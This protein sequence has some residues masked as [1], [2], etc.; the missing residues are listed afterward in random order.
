[1]RIEEKIVNEFE[2]VIVQMVGYQDDADTTIETKAYNEGV[3]D[4]FSKINRVIDNY[5]MDNKD[6]Y[7]EVSLGWLGGTKDLSFETVDEAVKILS[8][9]HSKNMYAVDIP[10]LPVSVIL[11][12]ELVREKGLQIWQLFDNAKQLPEEEWAQWTLANSSLVAS[13]WTTRRYRIK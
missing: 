10:S 4:S 8:N 11:E 1:M 9:E 13:A 5:K 3:L 12:M 2:K 7:T 6:G